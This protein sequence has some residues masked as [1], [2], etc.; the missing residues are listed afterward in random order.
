MELSE[1]VLQT[2]LAFVPA[3]TTCTAKGYLG[4]H[5]DSGTQEDMSWQ[6]LAFY[7]YAA[8]SV[9]MSNDG[10]LEYDL[11]GYPIDT[12]YGNSF[13]VRNG[14]RLMCFEYSDLMDDDIAYYNT[15][16]KEDSDRL[17]ALRSLNDGY[18]YTTYGLEVKVTDTTLEWYTEVF[19]PWVKD[20][21]EHFY[22]YYLFA[23]EFCAFNNITNQF[24]QFFVD[25]M[26]EK[27]PTGDSKQ[28][29]SAALIAVLLREVLF[30]TAAGEVY[31]TE[32]TDEAL[33]EIIERDVL[34]IVK[35]I[36]PEEGNLQ[37]LREFNC[38]YQFYLRLL[39]PSSLDSGFEEF[40]D[41]DYHGSWVF[42]RACAMGGV[43]IDAVGA[44]AAWTDLKNATQEL[45]FTNR[46]PIN[47]PIFGNYLLNAY[48]DKDVGFTAG[49]H[50]VALADDQIYITAGT[51]PF[52]NDRGFLVYLQNSE[53]FW[54]LISDVLGTSYST[55]YASAPG[56]K[57][58]ELEAGRT[59]QLVNWVDVPDAYIK[60]VFELVLPGEI[61]AEPQGIH[62]AIV[63][64]TKRAW[65]G[66]YSMEQYIEHTGRL[67]ILSAGVGGAA[68]PTSGW[69]TAPDTAIGG[70]Y[71]I[72]FATMAVDGTATPAAVEG[73]TH[74]E[75]DSTLKDDVYSYTTADNW[76]NFDPAALGITGHASGEFTFENWRHVVV[77]SGGAPSGLEL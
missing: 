36:S 27:Y 37:S 6:T 68:E 55:P 26:A 56:A 20:M 39:K 34:K 30:S 10:I 70:M 4:K 2:Y 38:R 25:A 48:E 51:K 18:P 17:V 57:P 63:D 22:E 65:M 41:L 58:E 5:A 66:S 24:N 32:Y 42:A 53:G 7:G 74:R 43:D 12:A 76:L 64:A 8:P 13:K 69:G 71:W 61:P 67:P 31:G 21:Y 45:T 15:L 47:Q 72:P 75:V 54:T 29:V 52:I 35:T 40:C 11:S 23:E 16:F 62:V 77:R 44:E 50:P 14:Y 9:M 60:E 73:V 59:P 46:I 33:Q 49:I 3:D 19:Y 28:W 1:Q